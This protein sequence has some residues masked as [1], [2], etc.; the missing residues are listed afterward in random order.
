VSASVTAPGDLVS[1][2]TY[3]R[4][5]YRAMAANTGERTLICAVFPK[6]TAH[7]N[8]VSSI[9]NPV[10]V[11][12][13]ILVQA[14]MSSLLVDFAVRVAP[15]SGIYKSVI[16]RLPINVDTQWSQALV[17]RALR[18]NCLTNAYA[19]LWNELLD[20]SWIPEAPLRDA[21]QRRQALVEVDA[22][23]ALAL[24]ITIDELCAIYRTQFP[25]LY[26]YDRK[27]GINREAD[28]RAAYAV[29]SSSPSKRA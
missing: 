15:K 27:A 26:G 20:T 22:L 8:G 16:D 3:Y 10:D 2:R 23:V 24:G 21:A 25:V 12:T 7:I 13:T 29:F 14:F 6:G 9:G 19:D 5:A 18:L 28:L 17:E 11:R 4:I 1:A